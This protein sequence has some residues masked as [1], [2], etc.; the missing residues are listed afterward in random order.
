MRADVDW[1]AYP[2]TKILVAD[3]HEVVRR[4]LC[5]ILQSH[6]EWKVVGE[7][8]N[9]N[10]AV[11]EAARLKP[12]IVILDYAMPFLTGVEAAR[13]IRQ[14]SKDIEILMFTMHD[15]EALIRDAVKAGVRG[16]V[17]KS[18]ADEHLTAAIESLSQRRPYFSGSISEA[19]LDSLAH[20]RDADKP[21][22]DGLTRRE[23]EIVTLIAE[24]KSNKEMGLQL[25]LSIKTIESHRASAMRKLG[26]SSTAELVRFA[27]RN[28]LVEP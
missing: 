26:L 23:H 13:R 18:D 3:D 14:A 28:R 19:L 11:S 1:M 10:R 17:L 7:V 15:S 20:G 24:G 2:M 27:V 9:G 25:Q 5:A 22:G 21:S 8:D 12:D 6:P 4:G 16:F